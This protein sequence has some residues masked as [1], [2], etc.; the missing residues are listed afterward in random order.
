MFVVTLFPQRESSRGTRRSGAE[1]RKGLVKFSGEAVRPKC[2]AALCFSYFCD[3]HK[4]APGAAVYPFN[5]CLICHPLFSMS[6]MSLTAQVRVRAMF[7]LFILF[8]L[9]S[10]NVCSGRYYVCAL[11]LG[12]VLQ[13]SW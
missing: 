1:R 12:Q 4:A 6:Q 13:N 2:T 3:C 10:T 9:K 8:R 7:C 11:E 5:F